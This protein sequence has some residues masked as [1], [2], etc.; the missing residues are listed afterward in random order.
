MKRHDTHLF[1][2]D[3]LL[4]HAAP[5]RNLPAHWTKEPIVVGW[6]ELSTQPLQIGPWLD[7]STVAIVV[8]RCLH[9]GSILYMSPCFDGAM[10]TPAQ[11]LSAALSHVATS[12]NRD[13][14]TKR[15]REKTSNLGTKDRR[16]A[17]LHDA[18]FR[19]HAKGIVEVREHGG[20]DDLMTIAHLKTK[21]VHDD[22]GR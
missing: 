14:L 4:R 1:G 21:K 22:D 8:A 9:S 17:V 3:H 12:S 20:L 18:N 15:A 19:A 5:I 16:I 2:T 11:V 10:P 6:I 7:F 13:T